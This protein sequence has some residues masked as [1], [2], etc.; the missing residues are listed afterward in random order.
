[1]VTKIAERFVKVGE[2][3][4]YDDEELTLRE[5]FKDEDGDIWGIAFNSRGAPYIITDDDLPDE[6]NTVEVYLDLPITKKISIAKKK[7][8]K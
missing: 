6:T 5:V 2:T 7:G 3:F 4:L 1:M 8:K